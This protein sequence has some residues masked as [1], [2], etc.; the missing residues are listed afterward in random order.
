ML[1]RTHDLT[2]TVES[3]LAAFAQALA[4]PDAGD[5]TSLFQ[6]DSY[7][8]DVLAL[9]WRIKTL[10]GR[11]AILRELPADARAA[12]PRA[13][14][15]A[16]GRAA[17][18]RVTRAGTDSIEAIL[19]FETTQGRGFGIVRL[20]PDAAD[21]QRPKAWTLLTALDELK[22]FEEP[23]G[24]H[25]PRGQSYSRDFRGPNWLDQR[26]AARAYADRDPAVLVIGAGQ[27]GLAIA[28]RLT[29]LQ[30]D[31]LVVD[32]EARIGDN[33]RKRYHALTLHNQVQVNHMPYM[34]FPPS[35]PVYI[36]KDKLANWFE[37]YAEALELN[38]W[39]ATEFE[40]GTYDEAARRWRVTL[41]RA[42][43]SQRV[44][45]PAHIVMATG[46]SGI[47]NRPELPGLADYKGTLLHSS[48]YGD[49]EPWAGKHAL[50]I[51]TGN[52]GHDIAQD[53]QAA[54]AEVTM[55][56]RAPTLVTNIEPSAQLAYAAYNDGTLEDNDLIA[57]SMPLA[58][59]RRSHQMLT[60]QSKQLDH[61][62]LDGLA[63]IG[64][65]LDF[66]EDGTG[67]QF[68]YLTRGGGYYFNVGCSDLLVSGAVK[69]IQFDAIARFGAEG[70]E[71][72]DGR[73]LAADLIVLATGYKPQE[74]LV[75]RLY[76]EAVADLIGPIWGFGR[77]QELR[78]MYT[79]TPQPGLYFI[80]G[81]LAQC[82]INSRYLALQ[83]KAI[84]EGL[85]PAGVSG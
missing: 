43:G 85:L 55:V 59:G 2:A 81:S 11:E 44:M 1:D 8:R 16:A 18:R 31:T 80:A 73:K 6:A 15:I 53:L 64:F 24:A 30:I 46:V 71:L 32:R 60:E 49:G 12:A 39:T 50:V 58:L 23:I 83:I 47:P 27:A 17:P 62:L 29:M 4:A 78:N 84:E 38:I 25:R 33:W 56:Q 61:A 52:S 45:Q 9:S 28:A 66:G 5:L 69:L 21:G 41:R 75:R 67:W 7:W 65:K 35:W 74:E 10:N 57:A 14:A 51:G 22:G 76:G 34:P 19:Q 36:P 13:F 82:R 42:D 26:E 63:R 40:G 77:G 79:R 72:K 68:K 37:A 48:Q 20:I 3:W 54:G 70:A